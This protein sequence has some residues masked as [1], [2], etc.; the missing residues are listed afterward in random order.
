MI[1]MVYLQVTEKEL[2]VAYDQK[3]GLDE[4]QSTD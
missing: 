3:G 4:H 2:E 1:K